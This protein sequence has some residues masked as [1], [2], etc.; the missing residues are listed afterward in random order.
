MQQP[1]KAQGGSQVYTRGGIGKRSH[2]GGATAGQK[3]CGSS[4]SKR[5]LWECTPNLYT[6][7]WVAM[8]RKLYNKPKETWHQRY[9]H[10]LAQMETPPLDGLRPAG[11]SSEWWASRL[12]SIWTR[13]RSLTQKLDSKVI[14]VTN[15]HQKIVGV[16]QP[17][18]TLDLIRSWAPLTICRIVQPSTHWISR[19]FDRLWRSQ[20]EP[21]IWSGHGRLWPCAGKYSHRPIGSRVI[22]T[23]MTPGAMTWIILGIRGVLFDSSLTLFRSSRMRACIARDGSAGVKNEC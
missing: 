6:T 2:E 14:A 20:R 15:I 12:S 22:L 1:I 19:Y 17:K 5:A 11:Q 23:D 10:A 8:R 7:V 13:G 4:C 3:G 18:R 9:S 21:W 16:S